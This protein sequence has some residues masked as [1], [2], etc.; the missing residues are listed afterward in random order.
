VLL[1]RNNSS[2]YYWSVELVGRDTLVPS[3]AGLTL[4]VVFDSN[5]SFH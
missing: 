1:K 3:R 4:G 5:F 2:I